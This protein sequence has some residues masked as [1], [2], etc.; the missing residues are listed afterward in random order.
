MDLVNPINPA[1]EA[2]YVTV[3]VTP[4]SASKEEM[5]MM[6]L[7]ISSVSVLSFL[8]FA[9]ELARIHALSMAREV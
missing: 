8:L 4:F 7:D 2:A 9:F 3:P 6:H 5:L 1:L